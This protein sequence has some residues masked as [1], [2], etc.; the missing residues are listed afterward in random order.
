M[1]FKFFSKNKKVVYCLQDNLFKKIKKI[2]N[3]KEFY[4]NTIKNKREFYDLMTKDKD[5]NKNYDYAIIKIKKHPI[6][7]LNLNVEWPIL[8]SIIVH[9]WTKEVI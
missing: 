9:L 8:A 5:F 4:I 7:F 3:Q 2:N 6:I 1:K